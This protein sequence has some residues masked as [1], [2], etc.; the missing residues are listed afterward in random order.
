M[1]NSL[2]PEAIDSVALCQ[3]LI[4]D[5]DDD[6]DVVVLVTDNYKM[7]LGFW[8]QKLWQTIYYTF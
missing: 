7:V 2:L 6:D 8:Q 3:L 1:A 4:D 5:A